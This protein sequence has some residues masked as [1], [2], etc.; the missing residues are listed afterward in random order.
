MVAAEAAVV[1]VMAEATAAARP[2]RVEAAVAGLPPE[3]LVEAAFA[4]VCVDRLIAPWARRDVIQFT[5]RKQSDQETSVVSKGSGLRVANIWLVL[6]P[7][8]P[9]PVR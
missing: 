8:K 1:V 5:A 2:A 7:D 9:R 6:A 4:E 3:V